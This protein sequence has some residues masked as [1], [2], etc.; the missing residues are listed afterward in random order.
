MAINKLLLQKQAGEL[1]TKYGMSSTEPIRLKSWLLKLDVTAIFKPMSDS[2]S[3]M[4]IK[5][6][7]HRFMLI[8]SNHRM[9]KQHFTVAHELYHLF[10]QNDFNYEI[11]N[12]GR[13]DKS[14]P[15]EYKADLFAAYLLI[16]E[17]GVLALIPKLELGKNKISIATI[18]KIEQ[19][20]ACSR[21]AL[22]IQLSEMNLITPS[23][24]E[25]YK[26]NV[27]NSAKL[28]GYDTNLYLPANKDLIIGNYGVQAK[29]LFDLGIIS[30][31][32]YA[33]LMLDLGIDVSSLE[34]EY[35]QE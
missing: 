13:F 3:G 18:V 30:E 11:S 5:Q 24:Y 34:E 1:R 31:S 4:A 7:E 12:A 25:Q 26:I 28:L 14:D 2:F 17:D 19:Y 23:K 8:N 9:G 10:I 33:S 6:S 32:H 22:L 27:I 20:Y 35:G 29:H 21:A 16:P 15:N